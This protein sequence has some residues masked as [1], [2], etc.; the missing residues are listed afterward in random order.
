MAFDPKKHPEEYRPIIVSKL[1]AGKRQ[2]DC[3]IEMWFADKDQ[4]AV[5]TLAVAAHQIIHDIHEKT[6]PDKPLFLNH[7][8][9][10]PEFR[11]EFINIFKE[12]SN[13]FKHADRKPEAG[14]TIE[15]SPFVT[16]IFFLYATTG[17]AGLGETLSDTENAYR[18]WFV[19]HHPEFTPDLTK[20]MTDS[21][22]VKHIEYGR[23]LKKR[24]FLHAM[25]EAGALNRTRGF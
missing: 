14:A 10:K 2:L 11:A 5:H 9:V 3:A 23:R 19:F 6:F 7:P 20:L 16:Q 25:L 13:F 15:F 18:L 1:A 24:E 4:V 17:L 8:L 12:A 22:P 21:I